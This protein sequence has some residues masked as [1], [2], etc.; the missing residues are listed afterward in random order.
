MKTTKIQTVISFAKFNHFVVDD[1]QVNRMSIYLVDEIPCFIKDKDDDTKFNKSTTGEISD[2]ESRLV[3]ILCNLDNR[4]GMFY[5]RAKQT[6]FYEDAIN[7]VLS[8]ANIEIE[9]IELSAGEK[10]N[11]HSGEYTAPR[12][13]I[14][15]K[16][17][18][19]EFVKEVDEKL[20]GLR[21][22]I[23]DAIML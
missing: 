23:L 5:K 11:T 19:I 22:A 1:E 6:K 7:A 20:N 13:V 16:I 15:T 18:K 17:T 2:Y 10:V 4:F 21:S 12:D 9:Q 3:A 8:D 14:I